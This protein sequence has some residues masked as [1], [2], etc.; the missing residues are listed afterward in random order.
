MNLP[1]I[2]ALTVQMVNQ[3]PTQV[4]CQPPEIFLV[5]TRMPIIPKNIRMKAN[6]PNPYPQCSP[7]SS[8]RMFSVM[9]IKEEA[10]HHPVDR[11]DRWVDVG[12]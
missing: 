3:A 7:R 11:T 8:S 12:C 9:P 2:N 10:A 6:R 1:A 4:A 5:T